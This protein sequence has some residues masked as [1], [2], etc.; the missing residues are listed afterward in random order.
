MGRDLLDSMMKSAFVVL[1][2]FT[3]SSCGYLPFVD[4]FLPSDFSPKL[5]REVKTKDT[6]SYILNADSLQVSIAARTWLPNKRR[7]ERLNFFWSD[8]DF[9]VSDEN[10]LTDNL[11]INLK[12]SEVLLTNDNIE[13]KGKVSI[14]PAGDSTTNLILYRR[15]N[16]YQNKIHVEFGY[17]KTEKQVLEF[18]QI[19]V[20]LKRIMIGNKCFELS[21]IILELN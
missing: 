9:K 11:I 5:Y 1:T 17:D 4:Y 18:H 19:K 10:P 14:V 13:I 20:N 15:P 7:S 21:P 6:V 3:V 16:G 8:I 2:L 12:E